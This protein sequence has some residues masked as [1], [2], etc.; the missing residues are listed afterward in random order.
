MYKMLFN[1]GIK[2]WNHDWLCKHEE[3]INNELHVAY[4]LAYEP[5]DNYRLDFFAQ[6]DIFWILPSQ[7]AIP[8]VA[9]GMSSKYAIFTV[10]ES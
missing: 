7:I 1:T 5:D 4:Y 2:P 6:T 8:I 10:L 3:F 9:G